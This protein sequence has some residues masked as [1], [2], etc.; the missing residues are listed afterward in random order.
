MNK[1]SLYLKFVEQG[2]K[3]AQ[4]IPKY[5]SKFSNKVF[6]N[7][8]KITL[9]VLRQK[10]RTTYRDIIELLKITNIPQIIHLKR[11]P[12]FT[13]LIRFSKKLSPVL[14]RKLLILSC[15]LTKPKNLKLGVDAT[16]L[17]IREPSR[18]YTIRSGIDVQRR[19]FMQITA[20]ALLDE[21]LISSF[22]LKRF[23]SIRNID[24]IPVVN[25]SANLGK[26]EFVS[27]DKGYDAEKHYEFVI[28]TLGS[29]LYIPVKKQRA[30]YKTRGFWR[31]RMQKQFDDKKYH[32]RSK[33]ETIFSVIKRKFGSSL[34]SK[35]YYSQRNELMQR[36]L[37]YNL[38]RISKIFL[39][40]SLGFHQS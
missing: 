17:T 33:I 38:D 7:H 37:A 15:R 6:N 30:G 26:I 22:R 32:Q 28:E 2:L 36:V 12:H 16:G 34:Q 40:N 20:C 27:A 21:Q 23:S 9:L 5:F 13:T 29:K 25:E 35:K 39:I 10:L 8:Q 24:F 14:V 4:A 1:I 18:Y 11:V 31:K 19:K 3:V